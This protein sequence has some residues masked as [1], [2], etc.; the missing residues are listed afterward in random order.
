[1][2]TRTKSRRIIRMREVCQKTGLSPS[3]IH[4]KS[5]RGLFPKNFKIIKGGRAAGWY[6]DVIDQY[7]KDRSECEA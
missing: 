4:E 7:I 6:E 1:M 5:N 2:D 3:T